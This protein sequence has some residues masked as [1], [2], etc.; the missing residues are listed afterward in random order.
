MVLVNASASFVVSTDDSA[1]ATSWVEFAE[2]S[3]PDIIT[4]APVV[5]RV[6]E[7]SSVTL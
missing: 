4:A 1:G 5:V 7:P 6:L 2:E 3:G